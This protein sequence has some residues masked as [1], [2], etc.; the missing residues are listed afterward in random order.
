MIICI[1]N[2]P[3]DMFLAIWSILRKIVDLIRLWIDIRKNK[4][5][6]LL[7]ELFLLT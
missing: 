4:I 5:G 6:S 2:D 1:N 3:R 7:N